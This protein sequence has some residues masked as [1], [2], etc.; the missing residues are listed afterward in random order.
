MHV[1]L[2]EASVND[3][4]ADQDQRG[5]HDYRGVYLQSLQDPEAFWL[6]AANTVDWYRP[7]SRACDDSREP[8]YHWFPDGELNITVSALDRHVAAGRGDQVAL[9]YDSAVTNTKQRYTYAELHH[10]VALAAGMLADLGVQ[11][12]DRVILYLPMIPQAVIGMLACA[13]LGAVHSVVFGGFSAAEIA[14]RID[15]AQPDVLLT[16]SGGIEPTGRVEYLPT[17]AEALH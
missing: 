17:V 2:E 6:D 8:I 11:H 5:R 13:R 4:A 7:P 9:I 14:T 15:D 1:P 16:A 10:Q 3:R 12:G